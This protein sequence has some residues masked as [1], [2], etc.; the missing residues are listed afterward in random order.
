MK[1]GM[2][3]DIHK[4]LKY[5]YD[6]MSLPDIMKEIKRQYRKT[7][8]IEKTI[9]LKNQKYYEMKVSLNRLNIQIE[10]QSLFKKKL[11]NEIN[12]FK[13]TKKEYENE[14]NDALYNNRIITSKINYQFEEIQRLLGDIIS[15]NNASISN[16][17]GGF[18]WK[19]EYP[20]CII[21]VKSKHF[22]TVFKKIKKNKKK[23]DEKTGIFTQNQFLTE[24]V[25]LYGCNSKTNHCKYLKF[26]TNVYATEIFDFY[27]N[28]F[29]KCRVYTSNFYEICR[30]RENLQ[31]ILK[32]KNHKIF[33]FSIGFSSSSY[34]EKSKHHYRKNFK[35]VLILNF[36]EIANDNDLSSNDFKYLL[37]FKNVDKIFLAQSKYLKIL[38]KVLHMFFL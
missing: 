26:S 21:E 3:I 12:S 24:S 19:S 8:K 28:F 30:K 32:L 31:V 33:Y 16:F 36:Y 7:Q 27:A 15:R 18:Q 1:Y 38:Y 6:E 37:L 9:E 14:L 10:K 4:H 20:W 13:K 5:L 22:S 29:L 25:F 11:M 35:C 17:G 34:R 2:F 23:N